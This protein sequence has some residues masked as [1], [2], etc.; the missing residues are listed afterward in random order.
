[1][2]STVYKIVKYNKPFKLGSLLLLLKYAFF[3][4]FTNTNS[5]FDCFSQLGGKYKLILSNLRFCATQINK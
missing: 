3:L 5:Y 2:I 1:M 4:I